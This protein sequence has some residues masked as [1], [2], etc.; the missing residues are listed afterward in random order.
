MKKKEWER[1]GG[2]IQENSFAVLIFIHVIS[3]TRKTVV[4]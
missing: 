3:A 1:I 4:A 2:E